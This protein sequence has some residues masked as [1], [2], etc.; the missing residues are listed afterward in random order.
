MACGID[1]LTFTQPSLVKPQFA[2]DADI[3]NIVKRFTKTGQLPAF[4]SIFSY[5]FDS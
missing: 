4:V 1:G 2:E 3:G 5:F